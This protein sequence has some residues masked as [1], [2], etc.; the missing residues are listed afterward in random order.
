MEKSY[1]LVVLFSFIFVVGFYGVKGD[2]KTEECTSAKKTCDE[3][4]KSAKCLW[5]HTDSSCKPYPTGH[6]LPKSSDCALNDARWGV[7]WVNFKVL[8]IVMG[9]IGGIIILA[10]TICICY[11]CCCRKKNKAK[12]A[13]E[14]AKW[15]RQKQERKDK[16]D[17]RKAERRARNDEIRRKYGLIKD[18]TPYQRFE[19]DP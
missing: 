19:D 7:C 11:C 5:C 6:I 8:L 3:C 14:D 2:N 9:C 4:L 1:F 12:Y 15:E 13:K 10:V 17:E 18:N 16:A